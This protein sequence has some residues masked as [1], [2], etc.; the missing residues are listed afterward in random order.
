MK[1]AII[2]CSGGID[3]VTTA[4]FI[5]NQHKYQNLIILL[6]NYAQKSLKSERKCAK[7]CAKSLNANFIEIK[8]NELYKLSTSLINIKGKSPNLSVKDLKD[9]RNQTNNWYVPARNIIFISYALALADKIYITK[10]ER[11]DIFLGFKCEGNNPY[12][13]ATIGFVK[14]MNKLAKST[15]SKPKILAPL[16][17]MDKEDI[18][19]L[20]I[21]LKIDISK[22]H[23]CYIS[24]VHCGACLACQL[25]KAG[26]YWA[27]QKDETYYKD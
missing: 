24:N 19:N 21:K 17:K 7:S 12:P 10:K 5:K 16:I 4:H 22:T 8:L 18:I 13:D 26:F 11:S 9:T 15:E 20:A 2:L 23:S 25:R 3:S 1:N 14:E 6:F 27:N